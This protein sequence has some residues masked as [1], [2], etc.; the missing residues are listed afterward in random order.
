MSVDRR[1]EILKIL[2]DQNHLSERADTKAISLLSMLGIFTV[3]FVTQLGNMQMNSFFIVVVII[4]F[5]SVVIAILHIIL[6]IN[7][8]TRST[9]KAQ[10]SNPND[11][12][13]SQPTFFEGICKFKDANDYKKSLDGV[14]NSDET[15]TDIYI[16]QIYQ[17]AQINKIKFTCVRRAVW[18][19][20][21][22]LASQL[23]I[24]AYIFANRPGI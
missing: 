21:I 10:T 15:M 11:I 13:T 4:Y 14:M 23:S 24:I 9:E 8:R 3:F 19:V 17:V 18:F 22:A 1:A 16:R 5:I 6:A 20:V 7:P 2:D 12:T